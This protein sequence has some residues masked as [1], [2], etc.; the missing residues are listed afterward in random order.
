MRPER[1]DR[2]FAPQKGAAPDQIEQLEHV[3]DHIATITQHTLSGDYRNAPGAGAAGGLGFALIAF[4]GAKIEPGVRL[5][6]RECGLDELLNGATLCMTGEG[7]IDMQTLHGKTVDGVANLARERGVAV[8]AFGGMVE[9]DAADEF[10]RRGIEVV[11]I[12]PP[13]TPL[14]ESIRSAARLL[15][16]A[17]KAAVEPLAP[18]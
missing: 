3:L 1:R 18:R 7:K 13:G 8:I 14:E 6:A 2:T 17:A 16:A 15:E 4:L 11:A 12:G 9:K 5:I 10:A